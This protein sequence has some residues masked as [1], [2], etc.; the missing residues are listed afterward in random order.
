V[1]WLRG[2]SC[3]KSSPDSVSSSQAFLQ[4]L[5]W[6]NFKDGPWFDRCG[7]SILI[8]VVANDNIVVLRELL[9]RL[10]ASDPSLR[11]KRL[12]SEVPAQGVPSLGI[13][14]RITT[15]VAAMGFAS[16]EF[17]S[18]LLEHGADPYVMFKNKA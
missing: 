14:G 13:T 4:H 6:D 18:L 10:E 15:L 3:D 12:R 17:V 8:Y 9:N 2:L 5:H 11:K 16:S 7:I 1:W